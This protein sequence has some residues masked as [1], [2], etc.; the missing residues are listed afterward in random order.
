MLIT[1]RSFYSFIHS[2]E[3]FAGILD[4]LVL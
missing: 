1:C 4:V 2:N 3:S